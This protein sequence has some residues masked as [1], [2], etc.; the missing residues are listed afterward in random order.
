MTN[1]YPP[2]DCLDF[3]ENLEAQ[4]SRNWTATSLDMKDIRDRVNPFFQEVKDHM[5]KQEW[6]L[7]TN[8]ENLTTTLKN[9]LYD[10][11]PNGSLS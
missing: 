4:S 8:I 3:L 7:F 11:N 6:G 5:K 1:T 2:F 10:R 9:R